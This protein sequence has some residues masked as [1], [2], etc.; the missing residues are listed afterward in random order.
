MESP[1]L[2]PNDP[3]L[4]QVAE[5]VPVDAITGPEI[6]RDLERLYELAHAHQADRTKPVLVGICAS[7]IGIPKQIILTDVAADGHGNVGNLRAFIN[8]LITETS[9]D[10]NE[11]YEGCYSTAPVCGI[12]SR[13]TRITFEAYDAEANYVTQTLEGYVARVFQHEIDHLNGQLFTSRVT[14]PDHLHVVETD[15]Y[16]KYRDQEGWRNWPKKYAKA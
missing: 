2:K 9:A 4:T 3:R 15:D 1:F 8:P 5:P 14:N 11:W 12:V 16:P 10:A 6:K 13:P 7:Q